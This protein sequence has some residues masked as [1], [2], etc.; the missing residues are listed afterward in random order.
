VGSRA[1]AQ[2]DLKSSAPYAGLGPGH[3]A[4]AKEWFAITVLS[5]HNYPDPMK[6]ALVKRLYKVV[7]E[8]PPGKLELR[9][10]WCFDE[11]CVREY[12]SQKLPDR[13]ILSIVL[14]APAPAPASVLP[15][16]QIDAQAEAWI[17]AQK[18]PATSTPAEV[19]A[20][21]EPPIYRYYRIVFKDG[22]TWLGWSPSDAVVRKHFAGRDIYSINDLEQTGEESTVRRLVAARLRQQAPANPAPADVQ[23]AALP[24]P[25]P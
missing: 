20:P 6:P 10:C 25:R 1:H 17:Q 9:G 21:S 16:S 23:G 22:G 5:R 13:S 4:T 18:P 12:Y 24:R 3:Y 11:D 2:D 19:G 8:G 7:L 14:V 15:Q